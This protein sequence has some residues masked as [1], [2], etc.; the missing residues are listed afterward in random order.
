MTVRAVEWKNPYTWGIAIEITEDKT[1]NLRLRDE[2]NLIIYDEWDDEIYVDLQLDDELTPTDDLPVGVTTGRIIVDNWWEFTGTILVA[3]TTSWDLIKFVY[4]DDWKIYL[5]NWTW[6]FK[7]IYTKTDIDTL[8][9]AVK[10]EIKNYV[11]EKISKVIAKSDTAPSNPSEWDLW[12][13]TVNDTLKV[14]DGTQWN[15]IGWGGSSYSAWTWINI[16]SNNEISNTWVLTVNGSSGTGWAV[17]VNDV[18]IW[19]TSPQNPTAWMVWYDS[20]NNLLKTYDGT[21]WNN[22][23]TNLVTSVNNQTWAVVVNDVKTGSTAPAN[24]TQWMLWYDT[25]N[26]V[27]KTYNW[28]QWNEVWWS[29]S[30]A[31]GQ[32]TGTLSNQTD[33]QNALDA[34]QDVLTAWNWITIASTTRSRN[35]ST[36]S[37][38]VDTQVVATQEEMADKQDLLTAWNN[39]TIEQVWLVESDMQWPCPSWFHIPTNA[40]WTALRNIL[41]NT[42]WFSSGNASSCKTY[43]KM[44]YAWR[45]AWENSAT[46]SQNSTWNYWASDNYDSANA[47]YLNIQQYNFSMG[48][49]AKSFWYSIRAFKNTP[50]PATSSWTVLYDGSS[51]ATWAWIFHNTTD[52][53]ISISW[54]WSTW[55][56]I[57][58]KNL[59]ATT[60][61]NS[62]DA[63]SQSNC[64]YYYQWGNNNG[65]ARTWSVTISSTRVDA[66]SNW[67]RNYYSSDTFICVS[68]NSWDTTANA[69]L[70]WWVTQWTWISS[71][72]TVISAEGYTSGNGIDIT[73]N[74]ISV[75]SN[76]VAMQSDLSVVSWDAWVTYI[77]KKS[78]T[79]PPAWTPSNVLTFVG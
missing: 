72:E 48:T 12:Y 1:I 40:E 24:P 54:D 18:K 37:I 14:Y 27:L 52:W 69:N 36:L 64:W 15:S 57:A 33:L 61:Y 20:S 70:R 79:P 62:W 65:F 49:A 51:I 32:V 44:P 53:L 66:S 4:A 41:V 25:T 2:N 47:Y 56:T 10:V 29:S 6:T 50:V 21:N 23:D 74:Q 16:D 31:W 39:I 13:D 8:L 34:K 67:P 17:V 9:N 45:R 11:D 77:I 42:F 60:V 7:Q 30:V 71:Y 43:L 22:V 75:D 78:T 68:Y 76:T 55:T 19:S 26:N 28:T 59:W 46:E 73:N 35:A 38:S 58:D 63:V 3:K 5:D